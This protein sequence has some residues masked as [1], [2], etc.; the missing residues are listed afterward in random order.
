MYK[1]KRLKFL[2]ICAILA[3][4]GFVLGGIGLAMG[5]IIHGIQ[6]DP[7]GIRVYAPLLDKDTEEGGYMQREETL[8]AFDSIQVDMEC[9]D[10]RVEQSDN[11]AYTLSYCLSND[12]KLRKEIS[13]G[14]LILQRNSS[15]TFHWFFMGIGSNHTDKEESVV[16]RI[17]KDAKLSDVRLH[18]ESGDIA[19]ENARMNLLDITAEYGDV[20]LSGIQAQNIQTDMESGKLQ[21]EQVQGDS[22]SV[23]NE[24]GSLSFYDLALTAELAAEME[25]GDIKFRDA[26]ASI[27]NIK[28]SYGNISSQQT[29]FGT[30]KMKLESSDCR[31]QDILFDS[32]E[33]DS[34]YGDVELDLKKNVTDY[35]YQMHTEYGNIEIDGR[36]MGESYSSLGEKQEHWIG[37]ECESGNIR[38]N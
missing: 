12:Q 25:S 14:T 28:N 38:I 9:V 37:I 20:S 33:I 30:M 3:G 29:E 35:S 4:A 13:D 10:I 21:M 24:Y 2:W 23:K 36:E 18:T 11:D 17:P 16:I 32:C 1:N 7:Q 19:C 26:S 5:G 15:G 8:E 27:L 22:C 31:L 6:I 34:S